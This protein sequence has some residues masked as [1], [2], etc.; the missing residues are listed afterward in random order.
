MPRPHTRLI[1]SNLWRLNPGIT[2]LKIPE[3]FQGATNIENHCSRCSFSWAG[4]CD[5]LTELYCDLLIPPF[6]KVLGGTW[7]KTLKDILSYSSFSLFS[8][9]LSGQ[10]SITSYCSP[11]LYFYLTLYFDVISYLKLQEFPYTLY[12]HLLIF[13]ILPHFSLL[14]APNYNPKI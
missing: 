12:P 8:Q 10:V 4:S 1:K 14:S 5:P 3:W 6:P 2:F 11:Q 7:K 13:Y 9:T